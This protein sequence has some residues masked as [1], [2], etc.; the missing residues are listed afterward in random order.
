MGYSNN[1]YKNRIE[2][3]NWALTIEFIVSH[4][5]HMVL[6]DQQK[7]LNFLKN[8]KF[9]QLWLYGIVRISKISPLITDTHAFLRL[10]SGILWSKLKS[11]N[12]TL[13]RSALI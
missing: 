10:V 5:F 4:A 11:N 6:K 12:C 3:L 8:K 7:H 1:R 9:N 2:L 13:L